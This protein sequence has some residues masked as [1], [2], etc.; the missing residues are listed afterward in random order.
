MVAFDAE[1]LRV[2]T[3]ALTV[4]QQAVAPC[5]VTFLGIRPQVSFTPHVVST[6]CRV[7]C[8]FDIPIVNRAVLECG[9]SLT[10]YVGLQHIFQRCRELARDESAYCPAR[11]EKQIPK[12]LIHKIAKNLGIDTGNK[13]AKHTHANREA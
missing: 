13:S 12:S 3:S 8:D 6:W 9:L 7:L 4:K 10:E 11:N 1:V 2:G 5:I